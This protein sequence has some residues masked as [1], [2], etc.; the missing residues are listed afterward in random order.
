MYIEA[1]YE[2]AYRV[3]ALVVRTTVYR[4]KYLG[5]GLCK[6]VLLK[7]GV[8][9]AALPGYVLG[10]GYWPTVVVEFPALDGTVSLEVGSI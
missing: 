10:V 6:A 5:V 2:P 3:R 8:V 9:R 7:S 4:G 1:Q